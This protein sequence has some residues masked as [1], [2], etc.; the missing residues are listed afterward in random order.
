M[1]DEFRFPPFLK[2]GDSVT[3]VATSGA[4]KELDA[5]EKGLDVW[6]SHGYRIK[7][8]S[9][10]NSHYGYLAGT[11]TQRRQALLEAWEDPDCKAI[12]C[13]RGVTVVL[14]Y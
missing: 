8:G 14:G 7:L 10:W 3:V 5:F 12:L 9:N 2:T 4:L 6:R 11:D 13:A 1:M